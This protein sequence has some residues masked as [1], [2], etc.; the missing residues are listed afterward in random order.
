M[1]AEFAAQ[2]EFRH[3]AAGRARDQRVRELIADHLMPPPRTGPERL[4]AHAA[5]LRASAGRAWP[6][7]RWARPI[8]VRSALSGPGAECIAVAC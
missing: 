5:A 7:G 4:R 6:T 2:I 3:E 1:F 8:G